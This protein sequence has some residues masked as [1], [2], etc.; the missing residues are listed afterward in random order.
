MRG[1]MAVTRKKRRHEV[2]N[3]REQP[4]TTDSRPAL[5]GTVNIALLWRELVLFGAPLSCIYNV[6]KIPD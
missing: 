5:E 3:L 6:T 1:N 2:S 4:R